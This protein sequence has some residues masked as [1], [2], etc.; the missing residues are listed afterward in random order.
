MKVP[1]AGVDRNIRRVFR[2]DRSLQ[3]GEAATC[4]KAPPGVLAAG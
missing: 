4:A 3:D 1:A 2:T